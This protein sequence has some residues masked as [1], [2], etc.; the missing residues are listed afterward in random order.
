MVGE[1]GRAQRDELREFL[2]ARPE[3]ALA[4][5]HALEKGEGSFLGAR[6][7]EGRLAGVALV[8]DEGLA[9]L[10]TDDRRAAMELGRA[11]RA[12]KIETFVADASWAD[13]AWRALTRAAPSL[14]LH[15]HV[16]S[17]SADTLLGLEEPAPI[18]PARRDELP[19]L[20]ALA[21]AMFWEEIR[22]PPVVERLDAHLREELEEGSLWVLE[23]SGRVVFMVRVA[24][25][26]SAGAE[27]QRVYTVPDLRRQG[28]ATAALGTLC[29]GLLRELPRVV[30]RVDATN[31]KAQ[32]LYH[33]LGFLFRGSV[34]LYTRPGGGR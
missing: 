22:R 24:C 21:H 13:S 9:Y 33:K 4:L 14:L 2:L 29:R 32:R 8:E 16:Y 15:Q 19:Q 11:L 28:I 10:S 1:L 30:L 20:Q 27:L 26:C 17:V 3:S 23:R 18:R 5:V 25:R 12:W 7:A 31:R 6:D 34:R